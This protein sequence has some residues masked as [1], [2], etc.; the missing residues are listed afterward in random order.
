MNFLDERLPDRFWSKCIPEPNTGCWLWI[1]AHHARGY[2][3]MAWSDRKNR[4]AHQIA[5]E[6]VNGP[7]PAGLELDHVVCDNPGC[8][9]PAHLRAVTHQQ[10]VTRARTGWRQQAEKTHCKHGHEFTP[11]N[12]R[13]VPGRYPERACRK[14][15]CDITRRYRE[16]K[17]A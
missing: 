13:I 12:T 6:T 1:G 3:H 7:V 5:W 14:C 16:R 17:A 2:G 10:N 15:R 4:R 11:E 8:C 9:N